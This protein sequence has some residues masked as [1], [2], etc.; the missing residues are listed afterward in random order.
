MRVEYI[1]DDGKVFDNEEDC[2]DYENSLAEKEYIANIV[3]YDE[4]GCVISKEEKRLEELIE[5][6]SFI[7]CFQH[8]Q[9]KTFIEYAEEGFGFM[10]DKKTLTKETTSLYYSYDNYE[11]VDIT[12]HIESVKKQYKILEKMGLI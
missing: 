4:N 11:W 10:V 3:F 7:N 8:K 9:L 6:S 12:P 1:S 2:L 5:E